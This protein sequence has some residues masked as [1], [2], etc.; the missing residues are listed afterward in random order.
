MEDVLLHVPLLIRTPQS[1][2]VAPETIDEIVTIADIF[3]TI[4]DVLDIPSENDSVSGRSL[5]AANRQEGRR[6]LFADFQL[7]ADE[8]SSVRWGLLKLIIN[9]DRN[10]YRFVDLRAEANDGGTHCLESDECLELK[11]AFEHYEESTRKRT[12][13]P[14][15]AAP[16]KALRVLKSLGY[17]R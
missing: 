13:P 11:E 3:P 1:S 5:F 14:R 16:E 17:L 8:L 10:T 7:F 6:H 9:L 15:S 2:S 12:K 4:L